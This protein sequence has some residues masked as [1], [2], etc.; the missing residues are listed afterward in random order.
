MNQTRKNNLFGP[1]LSLFLTGSRNMTCV[2]IKNPFDDGARSRIANCEQNVHGTW[3]VLCDNDT[4][5][6]PSP[7]ETSHSATK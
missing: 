6:P 7:N 4:F 1:G 2:Y 3:H 5:T